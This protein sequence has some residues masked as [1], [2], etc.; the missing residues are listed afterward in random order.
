MAH[1]AFTAGLQMGS[2]LSKGVRLRHMAHRTVASFLAIALLAFFRPMRAASAVP[3]RLRAVSLFVRKSAVAEMC[4]SQRRLVLPCFVMPPLTCVCPEAYSDGTS[5][6]Y[7]QRW[8]QSF[9][10][11]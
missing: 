2:L 10:T 9:T 4:K 8:C 3:Q 1:A 7:A 11:F 5:P 6:R